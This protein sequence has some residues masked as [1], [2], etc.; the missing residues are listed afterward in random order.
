MNTGLL[1][2][3]HDQLGAALLET[4][5]NTLGCCPIN[6]EILSVSRDQ[7]P[8]ALRTEARRLADDLDKGDGLLV[9]TDMYGSTPGN[10]ACSLLG[11]SAVRVVAGVN[12]PMLIRVFNYADMEL[13]ALTTKALSGGHDGVLLCEEPLEAKHA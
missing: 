10:I 6:A 2:I 7:D 5:S 8:E 4:A 11:R 9:L 12:L 1:I 3:A 13:D